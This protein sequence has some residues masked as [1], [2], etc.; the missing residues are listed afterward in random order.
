MERASLL[1]ILLENRHEFLQA[2]N[3]KTIGPDLVRQQFI[4]TWQRLAQIL[5]KYLVNQ[6]VTTVFQLLGLFHRFR[7]LG[8]PG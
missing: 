4:R 1:E 2:L 7:C 5:R 8:G 6:T 3:H